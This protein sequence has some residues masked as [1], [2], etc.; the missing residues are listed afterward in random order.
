M[1]KKI[2]SLKIAKKYFKAIKRGDKTFEVRND[3][4]N[5]QVGDLIT[6]KTANY[7]FNQLH[8]L[9][10]YDAPGMWQVT[11]KLTSKDFPDGIKEGYCVLGIKE[12]K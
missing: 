6:F 10:W 8:E 5:F 2:H 3:D 11:Y 9:R 4:R 7:A 12:V 1:E